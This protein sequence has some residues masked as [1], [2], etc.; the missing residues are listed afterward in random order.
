MRAKPIGRLT[1]VDI[2]KPVVVEIDEADQYAHE[3]D[4]WECI[5][6]NA[7]NRRPGISNAQVG[8][9]FVYFDK[10]GIPMRAWL[11]HNMRKMIRAYDL[12]H[13]PIPVGIR[14]ELS[15]PRPSDR[16]GRT[17]ETSKVPKDQRAKGKPVRI[18]Q[19]TPS[20]RN[21]WVKPPHDNS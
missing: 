12:V 2:V 3:C 6:A 14:I 15:P 9:E 13:Q 18:R 21:I 4:P 7:L 17:K 19:S 16:Y 10:D 1:K 20:S 11:S 8:A 5:I